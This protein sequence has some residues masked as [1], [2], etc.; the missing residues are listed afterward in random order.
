MKGVWLPV[1][2]GTSVVFAKALTSTF[3]KV[4]DQREFGSADIG[5]VFAFLKPV[6]NT[7]VYL[8]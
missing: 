3:V 8:Q 5:A 1:A 2:D 6:L 4:P 7:R